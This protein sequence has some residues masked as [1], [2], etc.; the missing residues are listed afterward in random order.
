MPYLIDGH[1]LIGRLDGVSLSDPRDE[2]KLIAR[3]ASFATLSRKRVTVVFDPAPHE[4]I[5]RLNVREQRSGITVIWAPAGRTA[6]D[7]LREEIAATRDR[8][9]L[10]VITSDAAVAGYAR[11]NGVRTVSASDFA[12]QLR[13]NRDERAADKPADIGSVDEWLGVFK[14]PPAHEK[15][16]QPPRPAPEAAKRERRMEQLKK[17]ARAKKPLF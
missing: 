17:Q 6:D 5:G 13:G 15:P 14:E 1:N 2:D 3:L 12:K 16:L 8:K 7:V 10:I 11:V 9:G 4:V